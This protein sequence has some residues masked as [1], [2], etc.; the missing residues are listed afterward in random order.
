MDLISIILLSIVF[1][2]IIFFLFAYNELRS[3]KTVQESDTVDIQSNSELTRD[4]SEFN[5]IMIGVGGMIG[6]GIFILTGIAA[7]IAGPAI[8]LAFLLNGFISIF[9]SMAYAELGSAIP[10]AGGGFLW[11]RST[12]GHFQGFMSGWMSWFA[13]IVAGGLYALGFGSFSFLVLQDIF[14]WHN[15]TIATI[16]STKIMLTSANVQVLFAIIIILIFIAIN[17][18]GSSETGSAETVVT[19][20]KLIIIS[21]YILAGFY[22]FFLHPATSAQNLIPFG[23]FFPKGVSG[24]ILAMGLTFIAFEGYEIIVQSGEE[25][26]NPRS[27]IPKAVFKSLMIVIPLYVLVAFV[28]LVSIVPPLGI[29][30]YAYLGTLGDNG[31]IEAAR[32]FVPFGFYLLLF[33]GLIST[34]SALNATTYSSSRVAFVMGR[35]KFLPDQFGKVN[36]RRHTP[37]MSIFASGLIMIFS[38]VFL[39]LVSVAAAADFMFLL[40]FL[41]VNVSLFRMRK[42]YENK[43]QYGYKSRFYPFS[44]IIAIISMFFLLVILLFDEP[45]AFLGAL[46]WLGIG[47]IIFFI[48]IE[49]VVTAI[50]FSESLKPFFKEEEAEELAEKQ[51]EFFEYGYENPDEFFVSLD[52]IL[53]PVSGK[54]F[55]WISIGVATVLA[56]K[57]N[58][59]ITLFH[60]GSADLGSFT[61]YFIGKKVRF[62][63]VVKEKGKIADL[64]TQEV[65]NGKYTLLIMPSRRRKRYFDK[66]KLD[67]ISAK[68]IPNVKCDILQIYS[69]KHPPYILQSLSLENIFLLMSF[70]KK[71]PFLLF[72]ANAFLSARGKIMAYRFLPVPV[73]TPLQQS[74]IGQS[75]MEEENKLFSLIDNYTKFLSTDIYPK[76]VICHDVERAI[77]STLKSEPIEPSVVI[78]GNSKRPKWYRLRNLS[79]KLIDKLES[80]VIV[81]YS[82]KS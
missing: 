17:Y 71:D 36:K 52:K 16:F 34:I 44:P 27:S 59:E 31:I 80:A 28:S 72:Y 48:F 37:H 54:D 35:D 63:L 4:L 51:S 18:L 60:V 66:F 6:A 69:T 64:I 68:V 70:S 3:I 77:P 24:V 61:S 19:M 56:R 39:P 50:D 79:D 23:T 21:I 81:Y 78:F 33:G 62:N 30:T 65:I 2:F 67:S 32:Q 40:L 42:R 38:I 75:Y 82:R 49:K 25:V 43:L 13:H 9:N 20:I 45:W 14:G 74:M 12:M 22:V 11:I 15:I 1:L 41:Q 53:L 5:I 46:L 7:G 76:V 57:Y 8:I 47:V 10:E 29:Q 26:R 73:I 55:E 58:A